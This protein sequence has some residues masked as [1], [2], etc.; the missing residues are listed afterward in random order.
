MSKRPTATSRLAPCTFLRQLKIALQEAK[1][2]NKPILILGCWLCLPPE[3]ERE[4]TVV[5]FVLPGKQELG[6]VLD[7]A[8]ESAGMTRITDSEREAI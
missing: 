3:L 4:L 6:R 7:G 5:E 1:T 8:L 2:K